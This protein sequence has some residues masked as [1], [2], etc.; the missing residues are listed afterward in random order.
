MSNL[1]ENNRTGPK[2]WNSAGFSAWFLRKISAFRVNRNP[3]L[4]AVCPEVCIRPK[5]AG[6]VQRA[7]T[8]GNGVRGI[9]N[10]KKQ[11]RS[12]VGTEVAQHVST[13]GPFAGIGLRCALQLKIIP[14][15]QTTG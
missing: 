3:V 15:D 5:R 14:F 10:L 8:D 6:V 9:G 11:G 2:A 13:A 4:F 1:Q 12:T 7:G